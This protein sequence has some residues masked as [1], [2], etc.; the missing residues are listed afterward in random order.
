M[1]EST[2][3]HVRSRMAEIR[4]TCGDSLEPLT[5]LGFDIVRLAN[6]GHVPRVPPTVSVDD[7]ARRLIGLL[8]EARD[9]GHEPVVVLAAASSMVC[10]CSA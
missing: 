3:E 6:R 5:V 1:I 2:R 7:L 4:A 9:N 8:D 10:R